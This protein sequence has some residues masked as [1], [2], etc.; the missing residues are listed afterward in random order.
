MCG[1]G[2]GGGDGGGSGRQ[3]VL[4]WI[5]IA[6]RDLKYGL[7]NHDRVCSVGF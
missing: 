7:N 1:G 2:G 4:G 3:L 5:L 6:L